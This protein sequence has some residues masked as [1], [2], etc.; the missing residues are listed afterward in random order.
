MHVEKLAVCPFCKRSEFE[1]SVYN[2]I[3][4]CQDMRLLAEDLKAT[5]APE[6]EYDFDYNKVY[7]DMENISV[8]RD[9]V[10]DTLYWQP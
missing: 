4:I 2:K 3:N 6:R 7:L 9:R 5:G 8:V 10:I 1:D